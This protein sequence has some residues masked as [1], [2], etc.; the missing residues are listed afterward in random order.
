MCGRGATCQRWPSRISRLSRRTHGHT[1]A[2]AVSRGGAQHASCCCARAVPR[3]PRLV[4]ALGK[5]TAPAR[6][7]SPSACG[8]GATCQL[9][10]PKDRISWPSRGARK[11]GTAFAVSREEV[12]H[13]SL[14][15]ARAVA[16]W[17]WSLR[18]LGK[19]SAPDRG[20]FPSACGRGATCHWLPPRLS[21]L[22]RGTREGATALAVSGEKALHASFLRACAASRW[23]WSVIH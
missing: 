19:G 9:L 22:S 21:R 8:H 10:P 20:L 11:L 1:T 23:L 15:R 4:R 7:P 13:A 5:G 3:W 18:A 2:L 17:L 12:H 14:F 16:R 6:G